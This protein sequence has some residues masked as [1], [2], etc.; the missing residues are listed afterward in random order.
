[1]VFSGNKDTENILS[2]T[3]NPPLTTVKK[4]GALYMILL[5]IFLKLKNIIRL[6]GHS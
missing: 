4:I 3:P 6:A 5:N 2:D 1:M